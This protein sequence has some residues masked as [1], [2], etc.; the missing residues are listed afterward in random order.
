MNIRHLPGV[1]DVQPYNE[2]AIRYKISADS[3]WKQGILYMV[4]DYDQQKYEL[5]TLR[6]GEWPGRN[7]IG[8]ER[9]AAQYLQLGV[10]DSV[11]FKINN[12]ERTFPISGLV[13][14]PF[15]PPPQFQDLMF[16]FVDAQV[17][18][19]FGIPE[20]KFGTL[21]IRVT[22]Y[23]VDHAKEVATQ[24]KD[25]L[26]KQR[27]G[28]SST[29]YQDPDRH[30]G[31]AMMDGMALALNV[32]AILSLAMS[33]VIVYNT[34]S[35]LISHET[36]QIGIMKAIG[37]RTNEIVK[38]YL[39]GALVYGLL[40]LLIALPLGALVAFEISR[41]FLNLFNIDYET[42]RLSYGTLAFQAV[43]AL[44]VPLAAGAI[45]VIQ[46]ASVTVHQAIASYGLEG[47]TH[48][49]WLDRMVQRVG[50]SWMPTRWAA[51]IGNMLRRK[52]R[53]LLT[54][55][56]LITAGVMFLLVMSLSSSIDATLQQIFALQK[57]E[58]T[59]QFAVPQRVSRIEG[60]VQ[61]VPAVDLVETRFVQG[62]ALLTKGQL[63]KEA[64]IGSSVEGVPE[65]S[66]FYNPLM[67]AGR[68][69]LPGDGRVVVLPVETANKNRIAVGDTV[70]LNMG[71][72]GKSEWQVLG[73]YNPVFS[74]GFSPDTLYAPQS[75]LFESTKV[76][77]L[78]SQL[79]IRTRSKDEASVNAAVAALKDYFEK[80]EIP[81]STSQTKFELQRQL[82]WQF[83]ITT[84]ML[85]ALAL[86]IAVV[87]GIALM[88]ALSISVVERTKEIGVLRAIGARSSAILGM[89]L[90]EGI[91]Q[92]VISWLI[93]IP[94]AFAFSKPFSEGLG[95][96]MFSA[97]LE[98]Q[99]N[100]QAVFV[101]LI[102]LLILSALASIMPARNAARVHVRESL[103]Y[104]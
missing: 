82:A 26:G 46:G 89:F 84:S 103:A 73:L 35:A 3:E 28:V 92:G 4:D 58:I 8:I 98:Y 104:A 93:S 43:S 81:L 65:G 34:I 12:I 37:G 90:L 80:R 85:L 77:N 75:A 29:V 67:V 7:K 87:G 44:A 24:I 31:R 13:R 64:G 70:L 53:L 42:F 86:I 6:A 10:G 62:V 66:D 39:C 30:W 11:I 23:S 55:T 97:A 25:F 9:M 56:A 19:R 14:H 91:L 5:V 47:T 68:W 100:G 49:G 74:G 16:F 33:V 40:A 41:T 79:Y 38:I 102:L 95:R 18:E 36:D 61:A 63:V 27:I 88:G 72:L 48:A 54:Q 71:E 59:L 76:A 1:E 57:Y 22:P 15:V 50:Q 2:I 83:S 99:F 52:R 21:F 69:F 45:P 20:G 17:M 60:M 51:V 32:L 78:G 94:I 96:A 101:W